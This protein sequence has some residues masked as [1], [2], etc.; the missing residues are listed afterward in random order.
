M[1]K[2]IVIPDLRA[3]FAYVLAAL[4]APDVSHISGL[5]FLDR[6]YEHLVEKLS[7]LG[8]DITR[9]SPSNKSEGPLH[10]LLDA[11]VSATAGRK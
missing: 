9:V 6:G 8:A 1:S 11:L 5:H 7:S 4:L 3:G 10:P 2:D